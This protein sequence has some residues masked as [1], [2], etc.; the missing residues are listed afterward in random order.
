ML[1]LPHVLI[2]AAIASKIPNPLISIPLAFLSH[3]LVDLIPHWNPSLYTETKKNGQPSYRSTV[4][5]II[6]VIL[7]LTAG[8]F[9][10]S[11]VMPNLNHAIVIILACFAAVAPDVVEGF[12][13]FLKVRTQFLERLINFQR[14]YQGRAPIIPGLLIQGATILLALLVALS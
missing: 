11:Q 10:A 14:R 7:S 1:E 8:F 4:I 12:Y 6:D 5:V 13:F 2:G 9:I 3:F